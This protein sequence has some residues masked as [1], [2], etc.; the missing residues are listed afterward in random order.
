MKKIPYI[1]DFDT[2]TDDAI[3]LICA[4]LNQDTLD[5][6]AI[7]TVAGCVELDKTSTNTLNIVDYLGFDI[8]VALGAEGPL[9]KELFVAISHGPSG[10]GNVIVPPAK[11]GFY[12]KDAADTIYHFAKECAGDL[13][14]LACGPLTNLALALLRYPDMNTLIKRITIM[15]G[16]LVGGNM[17]QA[18]EFN[19]WVDPDAAKIVFDAGIPL[20]MVGLDVTLKTEMPKSVFEKIAVTDNPFAELSTRIID[21]MINRNQLS[22]VSLYGSVELDPAYMHDALAMAAL[23]RPDLITTKKYNIAVELDG[24]NTRGMTVADFNN[25]MNREP[26]IDAAVEVDVEG[27]WEWMLELMAN[28]PGRVSS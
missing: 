19:I 16:A 3:A 11:R 28:G 26:N 22:A 24:E 14:L 23:V 2:G 6:K 21:F 12:D 15:G 1:M 9:K 5:I 27:F 7:T 10:L 4:L 18:S 8:P 20:T 13:H 17:T 25:V